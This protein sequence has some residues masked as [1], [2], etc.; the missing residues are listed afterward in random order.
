MAEGKAS[1]HAHLLWSFPKAPR[2]SLKSS[3]EH[4]QRWAQSFAR[5]LNG[6]AP[7]HTQIDVFF[8]GEVVF[9]GD[10][11]HGG[12]NM[13]PGSDTRAPGPGATGAPAESCAKATAARRPGYRC[14]LGEVEQPPRRRAHLCGLAIGG[15]DLPSVELMF[16]AAG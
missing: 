1:R 16:V 6:G 14:Q 7:S 8:D 11:G 13:A 12:A 5:L 10:L 3:L 9:G 4:M 15:L 2:P